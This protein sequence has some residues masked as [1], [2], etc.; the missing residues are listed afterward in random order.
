M[1]VLGKMEIGECGNIGCVCVS[2]DI[3]GVRGAANEEP[4]IL[5]EVLTSFGA[6]GAHDLSSVITISSVY[7]HNRQNF[8]MKL[9]PACLCVCVCVCSSWCRVH[10][11]ASPYCLYTECYISAP[12]FSTLKHLL[13]LFLDGLQ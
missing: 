12:P 13:D 7:S 11:A 3:G 2:R 6:I 8:T 10:P 9:I 1:N 5:Y 4:Y